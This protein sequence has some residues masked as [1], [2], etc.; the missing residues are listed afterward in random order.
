MDPFEI[1]LLLSMTT[2]QRMCFQ[3][4][5]N[6]V[7]KDATVAILLAFIIGGLGAHHFYL[8]KTGLGILYALFCWTFIPSIVAFV[9]CFLLKDRVYR[10]N[11][12]RSHTTP[13]ICGDA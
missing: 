7:K 8:G 11:E 6:S 1:E 12:A 9:E 5:Y 2:E 4:S 3:A 10:Y 13:Q